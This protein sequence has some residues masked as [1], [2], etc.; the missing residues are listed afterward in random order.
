MDET[1]LNFDMLANK[2][3]NVKGVK[4]V[5]VKGTWHERWMVFLS[6][7]AAGMKLWWM[8]IF[9]HKNKPKINFPSGVFAHFRKKGYMDDEGE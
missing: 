9:I 6:C 1:P 2:T 3:V 4:T 7:M 8:V 5:L